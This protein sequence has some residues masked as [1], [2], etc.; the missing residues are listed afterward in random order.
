MNLYDLLACPVC[1][2]GIEKKTAKLRCGACGREYPIIKNVPIMLPDWDG[3]NIEHEGELVF[4]KG[5][6]PWVP[7]L[8]MQS[9]ADD[10]VTVDFG[11]GNM[12]LD[13]P[14]IIRMDCRL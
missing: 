8:I 11:C 12:T 14:C 6:D 4:R 3:S 13:D 10:Q 9:F 7:S 2:I 1:K 5:Y